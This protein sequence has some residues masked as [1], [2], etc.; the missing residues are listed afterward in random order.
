GQMEFVQNR[1][2]AT[3]GGSSGVQ[4][5][6]V[7]KSGTNRPNGSF[8]GFFRSDAGGA[9]LAKDFTQG[10]TVPYSDQQLTG[11]FGGP[12]V[13]DKVHYFAN[14]EYE[15]NPHT[16]TYNTPYPSFNVDQLSEL[17]QKT[18][19]GR[20]DFTLSPKTRFAVRG[21]ESTY[22]DPFDARYGGGAV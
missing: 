22:L 20:L 7:T 3:Q 4:V 18:G 1:F 21:N 14:F 2:D 6:A 19:M 13:K 17:T 5:N 12:M 9:L 11:N 15:R 8:S 16:L 10:K